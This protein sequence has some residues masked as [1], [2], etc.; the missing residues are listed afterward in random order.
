MIHHCSLVPVHSSLLT[1]VGLKNVVKTKCTPAI[2]FFE[3]LLFGIVFVWLNS[4]FVLYYRSYLSTEL[5]TWSVSVLRFGSSR[6]SRR[7]GGFVLRHFGQPEVADSYPRIRVCFGVSLR[8]P[9]AS[10]CHPWVSC[11]V[12]FRLSLVSLGILLAHYCALLARPQSRTAIR[13]FA[14]V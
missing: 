9:F 2:S 7:S 13:D 11:W 1:V 3:I 10:L 12:P 14:V 5:K 4:A 6:C 8:S